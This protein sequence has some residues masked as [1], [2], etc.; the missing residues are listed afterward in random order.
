MICQTGKKSNNY[1]RDVC[2]LKM[3]TWGKIRKHFMYPGLSTF[4]NCLVW[5]TKNQHLNP[6]LWSFD[7]WGKM[8]G[9]LIDS[10]AI[11]FTLMGLMTTVLQFQPTNVH[12]RYYLTQRPHPTILRK[13]I[14][15]LRVSC[16]APSQEQVHV[17]RTHV[18]STHLHKFCTS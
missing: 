11:L 10:P 1:D 16:N 4:E 13:W 17:C 18:R 9:E 12:F 14:N 3:L 7:L 6:N 8:V 15:N 5:E 2:R